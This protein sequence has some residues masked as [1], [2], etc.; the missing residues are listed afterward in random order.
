MRT[1]RCGNTRQQKCHAKRSRKAA[2]IQVC[3]YRD[4]KNVE[5]EIFDYIGN[6]WSYRKSEERFKEEFGSHTRKTFNRL[7]TET[8]VLGNSHVIREGRWF[9]GSTRKKRP[10]TRDNNNILLLL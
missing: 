1:D 7:T 8:A 4:K 10:V 3:M 9:E 6:N 2:K 5:H